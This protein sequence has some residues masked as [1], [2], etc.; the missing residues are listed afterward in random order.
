M[1]PAARKPLEERTKGVI[2]FEQ[3]RHPGDGS[4]YMTRPSLR[5]KANFF[6]LYLIDMLLPALRSW[7]MCFSPAPPSPVS[8]GVFHISPSQRGSRSDSG[9]RSVHVERSQDG[10]GRRDGQPADGRGR[11][12]KVTPAFCCAMAL[13]FTDQKKYI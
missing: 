2:T 11:T 12:L 1:A 6:K 13:Q 7:K 10:P 4:D 9:Q 8:V 3:S 5:Q